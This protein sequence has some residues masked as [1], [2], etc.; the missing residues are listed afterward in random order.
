MVFIGEKQQDNVM[1][2]MD[3]PSLVNKP[4]Q[5]YIISNDFCNYSRGLL[6][7]QMWK[8]KELCWDYY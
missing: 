8:Y 2:G 4:P 1:R 3:Y 6:V 7:D 5:E